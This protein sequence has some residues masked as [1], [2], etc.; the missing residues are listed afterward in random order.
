[1]GCLASEK[2]D[3]KGLSR[4][5]P[6]NPPTSDFSAG[7][8]GARCAGIRARFTRARESFKN[9]TKNISISEF[10]ELLEFSRHYRFLDKLKPRIDNSQH[11]AIFEGTRAEQRNLSTRTKLHRRPRFKERKMAEHNQHGNHETS[12]RGFASMSE[13]Q[14]RQIAS[15]GG[16]ASGGNF[17]NDPA[18]AAEAGHKG[19][20][21]S[22]GNF[23]NDPERA[24]EAGHKGGQV[25]GGNFKNDPARAAVAGHKGGQV[26][27]GNVRNDPARA[28]ETGHKGGQ[29]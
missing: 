11:H 23:K 8:S 19:G 28:A 12:K 22:G 27:S 26:S 13:E 14:Q 18:R 16:Q 2:V 9:P 29:H 24:A 17:K 1:M 10:K 15:K 25:S 21:V 3:A 6:L 5:D 20:Q 7:G 4:L